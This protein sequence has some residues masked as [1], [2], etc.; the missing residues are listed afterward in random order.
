[1]F[2]KHPAPAA[3]NG[4]ASVQFCVGDNIPSLGIHAVHARADIRRSESEG[5]RDRPID[6]GRLGLTCPGSD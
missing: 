4:Q 1:M 3:S 2:R 6:R 5:V